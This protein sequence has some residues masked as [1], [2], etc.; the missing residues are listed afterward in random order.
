MKLVGVVFDQPTVTSTMRAL[1]LPA[2]A[3]PIAPARSRQL[4]DC[5]N[6]NDWA[7]MSTTA[8]RTNEGPS[9]IRKKSKTP[10][11]G[12]AIETDR[13]RRM[14]AVLVDCTQK[15]WGFG[16]VALPNGKIKQMYGHRLTQMRGYEG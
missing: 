16:R 3:H 5:D 15:K 11:L 2:R 10:P 1:G 12:A 8:G 9:H 13:G 14:F 4:L 7:G 6:S